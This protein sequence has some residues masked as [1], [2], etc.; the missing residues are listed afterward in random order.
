M[1]DWLGGTN[2]EVPKVW[3]AASRAQHRADTPPFLV[4]EGADDEATPVE[5]S[6]NF[7]E[8][9]REAGREVEYVEIRG[10]HKDVPANAQIWPAVEG[11]MVGKMHPEE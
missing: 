8:A 5:M 6:R 7:V 9:M 1:A 3:E 4:I 10:G 2:D 11:F